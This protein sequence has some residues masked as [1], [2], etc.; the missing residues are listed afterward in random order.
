MPGKHHLRG[1]KIATQKN[2]LA[3]SRLVDDALHRR[4]IHC[5]S[6]CQENITYAPVTYTET[7]LRFPTLKFLTKAQRFRCFL[8]KLSLRDRKLARQKPALRSRLAYNDL[9]T[10]ITLAL[11]PCTFSDRS[12]LRS[13]RASTALCALSVRPWRSFYAVATLELRV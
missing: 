11:R 6:R 12:W 7:A 4:W 5:D 1:F 9:G 10:L 8:Q 2:R 13:R 3:S